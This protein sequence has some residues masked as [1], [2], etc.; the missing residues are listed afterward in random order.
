MY[1]KKIKFPGRH[2]SNTEYGNYYPAKLLFELEL[3]TLDLDNITILYGNNGSGK[4]TILNL[5]SEYLRCDRNSRFFKDYVYFSNASNIEKIG[6]TRCV[7]DLVVEEI[8][9]ELEVNE[10][11]YEITLP[12]NRQFITSDDIFK[13]LDHKKEFNQKVLESEWDASKHMDEILK[14]GHYFR[15]MQDYERLKDRN[16]ALFSSRIGYIRD[17]TD[18]K[19]LQFSNGETALKYYDNM[20]SG[21]GIYLLDEPENCLSPIYQLELRRMI[22][23][24]SKLYNAQFII[25]THSPLLLS[26]D[27]AKV[28]NLD[29]RPIIYEDWYNL[30]NVRVWYDFFK[31]YEALFEKPKEFKEFISE[32]QFNELIL[33]FQENSFSK[34]IINKISKDEELLNKAYYLYSNYKDL[35]EMDFIYELGL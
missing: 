1:I 7:F 11:G 31:S 4:T 18:K 5:I 23:E 13:S 33:Y 34:S 26:I 10:R 29:S 3:P 17:K 28:Y 2:L 21:D 20:L 22:L 14:E 27:G 8:A 30:D 12:V 24:L 9:A 19:K 16:K 6:K 35:E 32:D 25:A 15:G